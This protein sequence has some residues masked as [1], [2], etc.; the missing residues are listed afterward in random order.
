V[1]N[2]QPRPGFFP[3]PP[4]QPPPTAE[5]VPHPPALPTRHDRALSSSAGCSPATAELFL[6]SLDGSHQ[7]GRPRHSP[8]QASRDPPGQPPATAELLPQSASAA[9]SHGRASSST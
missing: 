7:P 4:Q 2:H 9:P 6:T 5:L 8:D 1:D 3:N